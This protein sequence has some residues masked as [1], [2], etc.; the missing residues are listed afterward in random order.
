MCLPAP[1]SS[2]PAALAVKTNTSVFTLT[3]TAD[4]KGHYTATMH[5]VMAP[6]PNSDD[7]MADLT[8]RMTDS[9]TAVIRKRPEYWCW[10]YK[11]WELIPEGQ[12]KDDYPFYARRI[13]PGDLKA[14]A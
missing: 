12:N 10:M 3:G 11:R 9:M 7:P 1:V 8:Q 2:A 6:D 4:G 14:K 5:E 13:E